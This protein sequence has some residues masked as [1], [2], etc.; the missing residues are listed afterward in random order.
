MS[1]VE[2]PGRYLLKKPVVVA[3][4]PASSENVLEVSAPITLDKLWEVALRESGYRVVNADAV[5]T[6]ASAS[7]ITLDDLHKAVPGNTA[8]IGSDLSADYIL[9]NHITEWS[10]EYKIIKSS[11]K[12]HC[13]SVLYEASTGAVVWEENWKQE[14][15]SQF[16]ISP[17]GTLITAAAH[18]LLSTITEEEARL[19]G[20][21]IKLSTE[22]SLPRPGFGP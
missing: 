9:C 21:G 3:I 18:S 13:E 20:V 10:S 16:D 6:F 7:G 12:V 2:H 11:T 1:T 5:L 4:I 15:K 19:A 22:E 8:R 17:A 14:S